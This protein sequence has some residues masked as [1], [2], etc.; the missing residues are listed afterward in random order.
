MS[1]KQVLTITY[2]VLSVL[3]IVASLCFAIFACPA[4][5]RRVW[6]SIKDFGLSCAY[7]G[8]GW[9]K[10]VKLVD[11]NTINATVQYI[12]AGMETLFPLTLQDVKTFFITFCDLLFSKSNLNAYW[13]FI[14]EILKDL[15]IIILVCSL[16]LVIMILLIWAF[17]AGVDTE[18][19][20]LSTGMKVWQ[21]VEDVA[22][23]PV[24]FFVKNFVVFFK[25]DR[26]RLLYIVAF[27]ALWAFN[28]NLITI[29]FEF[30]AWMLWFP[31]A[32]DVANLLVQIAK[33]AVDASV[34]FTT[35][36]TWVLVIGGFILFHV[37][38][39]SVGF[40]R[41][42]DDEEKNKQFLRDHPGNLIATGKPRVGKTKTITDMALSQNV[43]F[44]EIAKEKS[45]ERRMEFPFFP[46]TVLEQTIIKMR[47]FR[48]DFGLETIRGFFKE[49]RETFERRSSM[50]K[51][52]RYKWLV[53]FQAHGYTGKDFIF[54]YDF[55]RYGMTYNDNLAF[56]PLWRSI[57]FYAE[58]FAIYTSPTPLII[59]NYPIRTSIRWKTYGNTPIMK[60]NFFKI[61]PYELLE[62]T[63][64]NHI[65]PQD[66]LR[67]GVKM[68]PN[69]PYN[70]SFDSGCLVLSELGKELGNQITNRGKNKDRDSANCNVNNDLWTANAKIMSHGLTVDF[71][72]YFRI[73]G[74]EQRGMS[75]LADFREL[76]SEMRILK[77]HAEKIKMPF[78]CV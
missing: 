39:R 31:W 72:C 68:D 55:K 43:L 57:E 27:C 59:G 73:L 60:A 14:G 24:V 34:I 65:V 3:L 29:I 64:W 61:K 49:L 53:H 56:V 5:A 13:V 26:R 10:T 36:P 4:V 17:Y 22:I 35:L 19:G 52:E 1:K 2:H 74:D 71:E 50:T 7:Y 38:R 20:K 63:S 47:S 77:K 70:N 78:F 32:R 25:E 23:F 15:F 8:V 48:S 51:E 76:G 54:G 67:L 75:I 37:Y 69:G 16:P 58:E 42:E 62:S 41:L 12:P 9:A 66:A 46:W 28:L 6:Q 40:E 21:K 30:L 18:H 33:L 44:R 45:E 11:D